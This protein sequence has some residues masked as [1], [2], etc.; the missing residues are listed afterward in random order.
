VELIVIDHVVLIYSATWM[1]CCR[2]WFQFSSV[3]ETA[4]TTNYSSHSNYV[5]RGGLKRTFYLHRKWWRLFASTGREN[6]L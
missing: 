6:K 3:W 2:Y 1:W 5:Q 4:W